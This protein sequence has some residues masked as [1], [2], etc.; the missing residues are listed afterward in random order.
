[1]PG[2]EQKAF[3]EIF[4]SCRVPKDAVL[5]VHSAFKGLGQA[6][7]RA[8]ATIESLMDYLSGGTLLMPTMS[9]RNVTP[10]N[11]FFNE[12]ETSS[13]TGV[14]TEI[15]RTQYA[16]HRSLHPTHSVAGF[17]P[18]SKSLLSTHHLSNTPVSSSSPYGLMRDYST[19]I[20]FLAVGFEMCT[21]IHHA[22]EVIAPEIYVKSLSEAESYRLHSRDGRILNYQLRRHIRLNRNFPKYEILLAQSNKLYC[23]NISGINWMLVRACDLYSEVFRSLVASPS[24]TIG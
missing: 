17:G 1:M 21:A 9:W 16:S 10:K 2:A 20:M 13:Q 8:E 19:Y 5:V 22:E 11:P 14:L 7:F 23:G 24:A 4:Q 12:L 3:Y 15:F 6:G 18:L